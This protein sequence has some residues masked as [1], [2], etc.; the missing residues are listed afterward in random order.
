LVVGRHEAD[1]HEADALCQGGGPSAVDRVNPSSLERR[2][3]RKIVDK[4][5]VPGP[6]IADTQFFPPGFSEPELLPLEVPSPVF[7]GF[8][9]SPDQYVKRLNTRALE[10][11]GYLPGAKVLFDM[12]VQPVVDDIVEAQIYNHARGTAETILRL[13][14]P[15]YIVARTADPG[16]NQ[17]P[18]LVDGVNVRIV[19]VALKSLWERDL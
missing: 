15:P 12:S 13:Y 1:P 5:G 3:I 8:S 9:L 18:Q 14:D 11:L 16:V 7:A 6:A 17:K 10:L 2:S 19:A 4:F